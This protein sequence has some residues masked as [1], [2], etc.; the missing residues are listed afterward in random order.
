MISS[1]VRAGLQNRILFVV[2]FIA[3]ANLSM[4]SDSRP[5]RLASKDP[6]VS[7][8]VDGR[9]R[10][11][12]VHLPS[13]RPPSSPVPLVLVL[14]GGGGTAA[15]AVWMTGFNEK[16]DKHGFIA[17]YPQG[18]GVF[19]TW[20]SGNCCGYALRNKVDDV[21]F[22]RAMLDKL[23]HTYRIDRRRVFATGISNGGMMAFRLACELPDR[24]AAIAPVAAAFNLD[25][26]A[27]GEPVSVLMIN[28]TADQH[29]PYGG[30]TGKKSLHPRMDKPVSYAISY[31]VERN[32]CSSEP[33]TSMSASGKI[34]IDRYRGG[35]DGT[36]VVLYTINGGGHAWPGRRNPRVLADEPN[37]REISATDVIWDFFQAHPKRPVTFTPQDNRS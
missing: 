15:S 13:G 3:W 36:E 7:L 1:L 27:D 8:E 28:G 22:I 5:V 6:V 10:S 17:V 21:A 34:V 2:V 25:S 37:T 11:Y 9:A 20:N 26:C 12:A 33:L 16:A 23:E 29:V 19:P 14:H 35:R 32:G 31:W 24:I 4:V 18:T 30:G